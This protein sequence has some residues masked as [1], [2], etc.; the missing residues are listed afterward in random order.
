MVTASPLLATKLYIPT[1]RTS[2]VARPRLCAKLAEGLQR[3][4]TLLSAPA[5]FG[6]STLLAE[7]IDQGRI[8][9]GTS[10]M[11]LSVA[12]LEPPPGVSQFCWL[13]LDQADNDA[14]R[15]WSYFVAALRTARPAVGDDM[16]LLLQSSQPPFERLLTLLINELAM[17]A[18]GLVV[19]LD[20]YHWI[21]NSTIHQA[22]AFWID[23]LPPPVHLIIATRAD[24]PLP[25]ARWRVRGQLSEIRAADLRF[26]PEETASFLR[27]GVGLEL[28]PESV[29][30][31]E[32]RTE[33]WIA[34][35]QLA[36]L[37]MQGRA[38]VAQFVASFAGS[39]R[40]IMD[41]LVEEVLQSQ[42]AEVQHF[43]LQTSILDRMCASLADAV[44]DDRRLETGEW[45]ILQ[46]P[47]SNPY[48]QAMLERLWRANLFL[49]PLDDQHRWFRYHHLFAEVLRQ[50]LDGA[51]AAV[52]HGRASL[53]FEQNGFVA[54]AIYHALAA[55][56]F[57]RAARLI[58]TAALSTVQRGQV[59]T[60]QGWLQALPIQV[61]ERRPRLFLAAAQVALG[62]GQAQQVEA[63]LDAAERLLAGQPAAA[64]RAIAGEVA[65]T[66]ALHATFHQQHPP[67][68]GYAR[69][70]LDNLPADQFRLRAAV[71]AG[72]GFAHF[73][74]GEVAAAEETLVKTL[75]NL[76]ADADLLILR[77]TLMGTL[78]MVR[79]GQGR[80]REALRLQREAY[81]LLGRDGQ[82]LPLAVSVLVAHELGRLLYD[83][84]Q[85]DESERFLQQAL[86]ASRPTGETAQM[87]FVLRLLAQVAQAR[88]ELEQALRLL[89]ESEAIFRIYPVAYSEAAVNPARVHI[90]VQQGNLAAAKVWAGLQLLAQLDERPLHPFDWTY[91]ALAEVWLAQQQF[92]AVHTLM[93]DLLTRAEAAGMGNFVLWAFAI[94]AV[95]YHLQRNDEA[96]G[97]C[98]HRALSMA[99]HEGYV[100][101]FIELGEPMRELI[102]GWGVQNGES[103]LRAF[104]EQLLA[105]FGPGNDIEHRASFRTPHSPFQ[106][107]VVP[108]SK[109]ELEVL[110]LMVAG[111]SNQQIAE[112]LIVTVGTVKKHLN[113]IYSKLGVGSR[114]QA[115]V[116]AQTLNLLQP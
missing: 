27:A 111:H 37:S 59:L 86:E 106:N 113:T 83:C 14:T 103:H 116:R 91:F 53:W 28:P 21:D 4:L 61:R 79:S 26:S 18:T 101:L 88:G 23:H 107:L 99:A 63:L 102:A 12:A 29:A 9:S 16:L 20:D 81:G 34:G 62:M 68:I 19:V 78:G 89:D 90:W 93:D 57:E 75:A 55:Y 98:L 74:A 115:L 50:R 3:P 40:Y 105:A 43:L 47:I 104:S 73:L 87:A 97:S 108:L 51:Q 58:E 45:S 30:A 46:S 42:P 109:R 49:I 35:L 17:Q 38:D 65:A 33:G 64:T 94:K 100:R 44:T 5:G 72:L 67:A 6:K 60:V 41:Y 112:Q 52:L 84:N 22:L 32:A 8:R 7:W 82:S 15:F 110:R 36:A 25:L 76:P 71:A 96:A 95:T 10:E 80:L 85:L 13:S 70:A 114:T 11:A 48:S 92:D 31:L 1:V 69:Q 39:H 2:H 54:E 24:P 77:M 56:D 66:R